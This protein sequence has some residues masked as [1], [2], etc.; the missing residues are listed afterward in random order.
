M[1]APD[2]DCALSVIIV[3]WNVREL[4]IQ[5]LTSVFAAASRPP[6]GAIEVIVVDN[7]SRDGSADLVA[8][9]FPQVT[10]VR[11]Q[12]NAGFTVANNQ[13]LSL[14]HGRAVF[15]LNPD[16]EVLD[17]AIPT[18]LAY[19][20][21]HPSVGAVGPRL[22]YGDGRP[23]PSRRRF[24]NVGTALFESTPVAWHQPNNRWV[25]Y[26]HM[27]SVPESVPQ[28]V[29][30]LVGAALMVRSEALKQVGGFDEGFFMYSEELDWCRRAWQSGWE[31][32][33]VPTALVR[34]HEAKSSEQ[35]AAARHIR[36]QTSRVRYMRKHHGR[37]IAE[38][39]R[40][41]ILLQFSAELAYEGLKW[42]VGSRR[43]LRKQRCQAYAELLRTGLR[44]VG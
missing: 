14:S 32:H 21:D 25:R 27:D 2:P 8:V 33:Y 1:H 15:F 26:L 44:S 36:F 23:Q 13:G 5:C 24:P 10:L 11:N 35:V 18:L 17:G 31:V 3:S 19:L 4:L 34:H 43:S 41:G 42:V 9:R 40:A 16:A 30:W 28:A 7:A 6:D 12:T 29:D 20:A 38:V 39:V 37:W 22:Q